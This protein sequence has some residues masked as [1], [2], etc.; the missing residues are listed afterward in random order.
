MLPV[1]DPLQHS[2]KVL[3]AAPA[4]R[5]QTGEPSHTTPLHVAPASGQQLT[6]PQS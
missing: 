6:T 2:L 1:H 5:Q 3:H 4:V